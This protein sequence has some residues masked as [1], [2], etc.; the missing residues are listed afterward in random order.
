MDENNVI[1]TVDERWRYPRFFAE[2]IGDTII[3]NG[4][5]AK[6]ISAVLRMKAGDNAVISDNKGTDY[7][8]RLLSGTKEFAEFEIIDKQKNIAEPNIEVTL[9]QAMPKNDKM[10]FIVQK[11]TELGVTKIVPF[12]SKR[13]VSRPDDKSFGKKLERYN[14]IA[15]E[16]AKQCGRGI[17]PEVLPIMS[18]KNAISQL[19][20]DDL[21]ILFYECGGQPLD[22]I[23]ADS[24]RNIS[25]FIGSEGGF[26]QEEVE[27][28]TSKNVKIASLGAR[29]LRCETAPVAAISILMNLT[30]NM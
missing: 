17:I 30:G 12:L 13:C 22:K 27:L 28:A 6:H 9:Y 5:D 10:D 21:N 18:Y 16:A 20:S 2:N 3:I 15:Y 19:K 23:I 26:E 8:C 4:D 11:A 1:F 14:R 25:V 7:L 24:K 29:I